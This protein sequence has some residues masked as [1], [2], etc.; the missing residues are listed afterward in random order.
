MTHFLLSIVLAVSTFSKTDFFSTLEK[1]S[2]SELANLQKK[3]GALKVSNDQQA[4]LGTAK[5]KSAEFEKT[6]GDKLK[7]FKEG[8]SMLEKSI[9][10]E[11][12]N[13]E[14][15]L[16]RLIIQENAP[17]VLKYNQEIKT[18]AAFIKSNLAKLPKD[19]KSAAVDYSKTS[20]NLQL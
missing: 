9:A 7:V 12:N 15:R 6:A 11:P 14:Y 8:K 13:A 19:V 18:D 3:L 1:G 16:L 10:A 2:Q 4:Y 5:M 20:T 17:K